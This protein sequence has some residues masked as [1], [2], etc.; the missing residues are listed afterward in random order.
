[1]NY[2]NKKFKAVSNSE[3]GEISKEM[4]FHYKQEGN[5]LTCEYCGGEIKKGHLIGLV[6]ENGV[7]NMRYHQ[8]NASNKIMT[9]ICN[10]KPE[11][12]LNGKIRLLEKWQW[13]S[14][15]LSKGKSVLE[16]V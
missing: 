15:D 5:I 8:I 10:S 16:E 13:T 9:G 7:I 4:I 3:N 1:M 12:M 6:D 14:G 2:N 11:K